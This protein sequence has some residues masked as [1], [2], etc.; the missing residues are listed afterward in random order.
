MNNHTGGNMDHVKELNH[1]AK[2]TSEFDEKLATQIY[3]VAEEMQDLGESVPNEQKIVDAIDT[4]ADKVDEIEEAVGE[5]LEEVQD[6][7]DTIADETEAGE[8]IANKK[9]SGYVAPNSSSGLINEGARIVC[10]N[11]LQGI[12]EGRIYVVGPQ[13]EPGFIVV[14]EEDGTDVGIYKVERFCLDNKEI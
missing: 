4:V 1:V 13:V 14:K 3:E 12:Y 10:L 11:P 6:D 8:K 2:T 9:K 7:L 5:A